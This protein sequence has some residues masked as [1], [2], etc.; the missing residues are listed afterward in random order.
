MSFIDL[1]HQAAPDRF[2]QQVVGRRSYK[3]TLTTPYNGLLGMLT[4]N[5]LQSSMRRDFRKVR[6]QPS[7]TD[8]FGSL[9]GGLDWGFVPLA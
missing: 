4:P 5:L 1:W 2:E 8:T 7:A 6:H 9:H 3:T